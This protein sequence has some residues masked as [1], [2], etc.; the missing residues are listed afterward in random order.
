MGLKQELISIVRRVA[1]SKRIV[2]SEER[3]VIIVLS[4]ADWD[5]L[6]STLSI[7][8]FGDDSEW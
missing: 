4:T 1:F 7:A 3:K 8:S 2:M 5:Q 6:V